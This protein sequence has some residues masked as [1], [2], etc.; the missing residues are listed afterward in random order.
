ML[1]YTTADIVAVSPSRNT[2]GHVHT[3]FR[4]SPI[5]MDSNSSATD[6]EAAAAATA[7]W[8]P[9]RYCCIE[10]ALHSW[11]RLERE[12]VLDTTPL[13]LTQRCSVNSDWTAHVSCLMHDNAYML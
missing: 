5:M 12:S 13:F 4:F 3:V 2:P 6:S 11:T 1:P 9:P 8:L 7:S 10:P